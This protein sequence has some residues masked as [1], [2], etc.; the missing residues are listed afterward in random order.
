MASRSGTGA[1]FWVFIAML[2]VLHLVLH[3]ALGLGGA[4]PDILTIAV[5]LASRRLKGSGAAA[6]GLV[7]GILNDALSLTT[8]GALALVYAIVGFLGARSRDLFEGDSLLFVA[9]YVFLGKWLRDALYFVVTRSAH[10]EPWG[11]LLTAAP[12]AAIFAAFSAMIAIMLYRA[13]TGE[14]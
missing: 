7:L 3:V 5:L 4:V 2:V 1:P 9:V 11:N 13:A 8:F 12:V 14:R 10:G 6:V